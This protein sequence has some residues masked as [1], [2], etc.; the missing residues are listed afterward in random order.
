MTRIDFYQLNPS[1]RAED[2][3]CRLCE[4]AY[5]QQQKVLVLT[6]DAE[7]TERL[8]Q[9]LWVYEDDSFIPHDIEEVEGMTT[10]V[11]IQDNPPASSHREI[12]INLSADIPEFFAQFDRVLELV[13]EDNRS[14]ARDRYRFYKDRGY[15]LHHHNL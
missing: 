6:R 12:L 10:P 3:V 13:T 9:L 15:E 7:Q 4:K 2:V 11:L 1:R 14:D 5:T 8:D